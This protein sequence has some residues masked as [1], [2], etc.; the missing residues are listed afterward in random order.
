MD[1]RTAI[2]R[3]LSNAGIAVS[4]VEHSAGLGHGTLAKA[5]EGNRNLSLDHFRQVLA[6]IAGRDRDAAFK[7]LD[8]LISPTGFTV[9]ETPGD[10]VEKSEFVGDVKETLEF[11]SRHVEAFSDGIVDRNEYE[12]LHT[13]W[14]QAQSR[15]ES[16]LAT[17]GKALE[18][19]RAITILA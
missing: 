13:V 1:A 2:L 12:E 16:H 4:E 6:A 18:K 11:V 3:I 15:V 7:L 10:G 9:I 14:R 19:V 5:L 17:I 8:W